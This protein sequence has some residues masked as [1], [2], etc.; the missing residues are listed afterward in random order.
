MKQE[1][2]QIVVF[3]KRGT[4]V[5]ST[6]LAAKLSERFPGLLD[7]IVLPINEKDLS[8]PLVIFNRG[9]FNLTITLT[10][11]SF[12]YKANKHKDYFSI[13]VDILTCLEELDYSFERLGYLSTIFH[14][15]KDKEKCEALR[16]TPG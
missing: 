8:Q 16:K 10:D 3:F 15:R 4:M 13:I 9:I 12:I 6:K 7:P 2:K 14:D 5:E 11:M 1:E